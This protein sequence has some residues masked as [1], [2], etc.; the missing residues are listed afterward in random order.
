[1]AAGEEKLKLVLSAIDKTAAPIRAVNRR[2]ESMLAPV[3]KVKNAF[4]ALADEAGLPRLGRGLAKLGTLIKRIAIG[5]VA[6]GVGLLEFARRTADSVDSLSEMT[7]LIGIGFEDF[8]RFQ[9]AAQRAGVGAE[10]FGGAIRFL[11]KSL[12]KARAGEG[13]LGKLLK[14]HIPSVL[15]RLK[16][17]KDTGEALELVLETMR[18]LPDAAKRNAFA[19]AAF[20]RSAQKMALFAG[21]S[22]NELR[23]L[24]RRADELGGV[25]SN[26]A[27]AAAEDLMDSFDDLA[28]SAK[29]LA[30]GIVA[31]L[32]PDMKAATDQVLA[33]VAANREL[34]LSKGKE[35][36]LAFATGVKDLGLFLTE[37]V[38]KLQQ[39]V[40]DVGGLKTVLVGIAAISL[41]P[42]LQAVVAIGIA[43]GGPVS[44][45]LAL[46][47]AL[48]YVLTHLDQVKAGMRTVAGAFGIGGSSVPFTPQAPG[49]SRV[50]EASDAASISRLDVSGVI[51]VDVSD[52]RAK[53]ARAVSSN[54]MIQFQDVS[55]GIAL[56][57]Q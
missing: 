44:A 24:M 14:D 2:I 19:V 55:R 45:A 57:A 38:P 6:A 23:A 47:S 54:P 27:A 13:S 30:A 28:F 46:A 49:A 40:S 12:E 37:N 3:R 33:F 31:E 21:M 5:G 56:G 17:T 34:I 39:F 9:F 52:K 51:G 42:V 15:T 35:T 8:Q 32:F 36:I 25:L 43:L 1:M 11:A 22:E 50:R 18:R 4:R 41:A 20:G 48:A 16:A 29:G 7:R 53:V 26:R 10:E